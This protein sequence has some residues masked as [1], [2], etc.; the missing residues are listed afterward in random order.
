MLVMMMIVTMVD[1]YDCIYDDDSGV[2]FL[3]VQ[4]VLDHPNICRLQE[5]FC[6][7]ERYYVVTD[8]CRY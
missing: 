4:A 1:G 6:S 3:F 8:L 7:E 2:I 5:I